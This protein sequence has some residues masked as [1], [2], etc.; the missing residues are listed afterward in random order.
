MIKL[1]LVLTALFTTS[2]LLAQNISI[3][4]C[5]YC[6]TDSTY[7]VSQR[8]DI[9]DNPCS[10]VKVYANDIIGKIEF[11]GNIVGE[12]VQKGNVYIIYVLNKTKRINV[13]HNDYVPQVID[14]TT[15]EDSRTG[16]E[17]NKVYYVH[18]EGDEDK[19]VS[20][21]SYPIG[22]RILSITSK[23]K[24]ERII[25]NG[26]DWELINNEAQKLVPY[27]SYQYEVFDIKGNCSKG[28]VELLPSLGSKIV[29]INFDE[30]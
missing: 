25:V 22:S 1:N 17:G 11:K 21:I 19:A 7:I 20:S 12:V 10:I 6:P 23:T 18:L 13:F 3:S 14:F 24:L 27:G 8:Y 2:I 9:N 16:V 5:K 26:I 28:T 15:Y 29:K 4:D 30:K